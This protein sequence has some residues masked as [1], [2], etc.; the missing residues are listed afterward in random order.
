MVFENTN[1]YKF[2]KPKV[3]KKLLLGTFFTAVLVIAGTTNA[4]AQTKSA[5]P[6]IKGKKLTKAVTPEKKIVKKVVNKNVTAAPSNAKTV[7]AKLK[8]IEK[9][10]NNVKAT[11]N[12]KNLTA[13]PVKSATIKQPKG[14]KKD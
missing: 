3:M 9:N 2:L 1:P 12:A 13:T 14:N 5:T 6:V 10:A 11:K 4:N 7:P 8:P